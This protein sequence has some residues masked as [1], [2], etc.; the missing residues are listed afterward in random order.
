MCMLTIY[1]TDEQYEMAMIAAQI[2]EGTMTPRY[3]H[4]SF[5]NEPNLKVG[6]EVELV[7]SSGHLKGR[8]TKIDPPDRKLTDAAKHL[9]NKGFDE[10]A[11]VFQ[12]VT[13]I[14]PRDLPNHDR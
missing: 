13:G 7:T 8:A 6:D 3:L 5:E 10:A 14:D 4:I 1:L 9:R 2:H 12:Q 11:K